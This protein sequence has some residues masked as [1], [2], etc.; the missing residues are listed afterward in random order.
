M[1]KMI[2][3]NPRTH[4]GYDV[5][6]NLDK[7]KNKIYFNPRTHEG[8]DVSYISSCLQHLYF[9]PR[10]HEGYDLIEKIF[11]TKIDNFNPRTHEGYDAV[12]RSIRYAFGISIHVPTK[13][14][15]TDV[16]LPSYR[17]IFQSTYPRRVRLR[18]AFLLGTQ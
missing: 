17:T 6:W 18:H 3:F 14:T 15:T 1:Q 16:F 12:E 4:E 2:Y 9:N 5:E 8:Y 7:R 13:G 10:T 11:H